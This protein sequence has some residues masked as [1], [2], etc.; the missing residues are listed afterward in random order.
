MKLMLYINLFAREHHIYVYIDANAVVAPF[1]TFT[2]KLK[3]D[4]APID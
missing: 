4:Q 1:P 3:V 2:R